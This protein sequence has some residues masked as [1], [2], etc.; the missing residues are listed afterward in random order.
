MI[1]NAIPR[2]RAVAYQQ[3]A[4]QWL[5]NIG[6]NFDE[7]DP[8]TWTK[9]N[10]PVQSKINTFNAYGVPHEKFM[11][12]ARLE[13]GV[14]EPF[15]RI[16][17]TDQLLV[18]FDSLNITLPNRTDKS[19]ITAWEHIDQSPLR[20]GLHCVQG[21]I[22]LSKT[23]PLDGGLL[24]YPGSHLFHDEFFDTQTDRDS[25]TRVD[26]YPFNE[27][28]L[29]WF[30][31]RGIKPH[32]VCADVGDLILW[33]SRTI[34][35]GMEPPE[36]CETIRTVIYAAYTPARFAT[37]EA[38]KQKAEVFRKWLGTAHWPHDNIVDPSITRTV[39]AIREDGT[40]DPRNKGE[41]FEKPDMSE[42]LLKLAGVLPYQ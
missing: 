36:G 31:S 10:L 42:K 26:R 17:G 19:R 18:S 40:R 6:P 35:Y 5:K 22:N 11:W 3:K 37:S 27:E 1:K 9:E 23:G 24:V 28:Q 38:L 21:I 41:P 32:K 15:S 14:L 7:S 2:E 39:E 13:P 8:K 34:H 25:W 16:W 12:D 20:R 29:S 33:D 4:F 30:T